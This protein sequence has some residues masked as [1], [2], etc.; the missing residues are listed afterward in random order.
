MGFFFSL[1]YTQTI[2]QNFGCKTTSVE[3]SYIRSYYYYYFY[4]YLF[5]NVFGRCVRIIV[6][7]VTVVVAAAVKLYVQ[8]EGTLLPVV[9]CGHLHQFRVWYSFVRLYGC[10][11]VS[12]Q[13]KTDGE[14]SIFVFGIPHYLGY[15]R[16]YMY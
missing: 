15:L 7:V 14:E 6:A 12:R 1:R 5:L 4:Y 11:L 13:G 10:S 2:I 9:R 16:V 3:S 8:V